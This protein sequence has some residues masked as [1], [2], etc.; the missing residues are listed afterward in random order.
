LAFSTL[1]A[2]DSPDADQVRRLQD[3][4]N[5][6]IS[7]QALAAVWSYPDP[8]RHLGTLLEVLVRVL[9]MDFAF[10]RIGD[11]LAR[12]P[13]EV[14]RLAQSRNPDG[15]AREVRRVLDPWLTGDPPTER[16][17]V[18]NPFAEGDVTIVPVRL[19]LQAEGGILV[20]ASHR[21]GF[22][23]GIDMLLLRSGVNQATI[24]LHEARLLHS[25]RQPA[26]E[27]EQRVTART[28]QLTALN[29]ELATQVAERQRTEGEVRALKDELAFELAGMTGLH[30]LSMRRR[31]SPELQLLLDEVLDAVIALHGADFGNVQLYDPDLRALTIVAQRGFRQD[32]LDH[33]RTV[34]EESAVCGRALQ[35]Q[36][37]VVVED[38]ELDPGFAPHR[39]I[40]AAAG[41]R[42]VQSTPLVSRNGNLLGMIS[43][44][45]RL[46]HRPSEH[47]LR[48]TDL[49]ASQAADMIER[50]RRE[51]ALLRSEARLAQ[52]ESISHTGSWAWNPVTGELFWSREHYRIFGLDPERV[53]PAYP[54]M[55]QWI[56]ADDRS[57]LQHTF[58]AAV[59]EKKPYELECR[60]VRPD[61]VIRHIHSK[62]HP[63]VNESG[64]LVEFVGAIMDITE[65][66][67]SEDAVRRAQDELAHVT[68][69]MSMG[70]LTASI[71]HE[72]NQPLAAIVANAGACL[73][74]L[75]REVPDLDEARRA[76]ERIASDGTRAGD[77]ARGIRAFSKRAAL[78]K[79]W[80]SMNTV[81]E[82][83]LPL[84]RSEVL[85][86][87]ASL[88]LA[89][90][91]ALPPVLGDRVQLQQV[92]LNL[93]LNAIEAVAPVMDRP[94]ELLV[95]S[96]YDAGEVLVTVR[97]SGIGLDAEMAERLFDPFVTSKPEGMGLGLSISRRI[98][99]AHGGRL[100]A[101]A[102]NDHG[103]TLSFTLPAAGDTTA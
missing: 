79:S 54:A 15:A 96:S 10:A 5:D 58:D 63:V 61:G 3:C 28:R 47:L 38:V 72:L 53:K 100:W 43:T 14:V 7:I 65:R 77:V 52:G 68:R 8:V 99:E 73:R 32:F 18:P 9:R 21:S 25:Q 66:R 40:A 17:V 87:Q 91:P 44:H 11:G 33:F 88:R 93:V 95:R 82:D 59:R 42:A 98:I 92:I 41:F 16:V 23:T 29:E 26:G 56:H 102:N 83:V 35:Q 31:G 46:P 89:L 57:M 45:F 97:D 6:L 70:E 84:S 22:P 71:V 74:W 62:A 64:D 67:Q 34:H 20:A 37:R 30:A 1:A 86:H 51:A 85:R 39:L 90:S 12:S 60:V 27:L 75:D 69:V 94:R 2:V 24:G 101:T 81:I 4:I 78:Q 50:E 76:A 80:L 36:S 19:G 55:L 48:L 103:A 13:I 49:Y